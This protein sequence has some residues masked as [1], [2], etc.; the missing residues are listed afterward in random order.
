[1]SITW[2]QYA[3]FVLRHLPFWTFWLTLG[4]SWTPPP[5]IYVA[6]ENKD[7]LLLPGR[8]AN[9]PAQRVCPHYL[10]NYPVLPRSC[11]PPRGSTR[12]TFQESASL[13]PLPAFVQ[14]LLLIA[15]RKPSGSPL[16]RR[17]S[18][19]RPASCSSGAFQLRI[20]CR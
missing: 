11:R 17:P 8:R 15:A 20:G 19:H 18:Q 3:H 14:L 16:R 6:W 5:C 12:P 10:S 1:M 4:E 7:A 9:L 2:L 13:P